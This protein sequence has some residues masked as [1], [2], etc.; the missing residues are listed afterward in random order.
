MTRTGA[1][2][3][4]MGVRMGGRSTSEY[5]SAMMNRARDDSDG[6]ARAR[7][8]CED[9]REVHLRVHARGGAC[10]KKS[11]N[12]CRMAFLAESDAM[13]VVC[14]GVL[15]SPMHVVCQKACGVKLCESCWGTFSLNSSGRP[16]C[17]LCK[18]LVFPDLTGKDHTL[19]NVMSKCVR[20]C[21]HEGCGESALPHDEMVAHEATCGHALALCGDCGA[22][23]KAME[24]AGHAEVCTKVPC[25]GARG[26]WKRF[27]LRGGCAFKGTAA[28][29]ARHRVGCMHHRFGEHLRGLVSKVSEYE[30]DVAGREAAANARLAPQV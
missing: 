23:M 13:C 29:A 20:L 17:P 22:C 8:G 21:S 2:G 26:V 1:L 24:M 12:T 3:R 9:G 18:S 27:G 14:Q 19:R 10:L 11:A 4:A 5:M 16:R 28:A 25:G 7:D 6:R 15:V 30:Q